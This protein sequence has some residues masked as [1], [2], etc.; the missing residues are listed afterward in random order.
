M[1]DDLA[2]VIALAIDQGAIN[3]SGASGQPT[4][5]ITTAGIGSV[6]GTSIAYAGIVEFQTDVAASNALTDGCAYLAPP[7]VAGLLMQRQRFSGT[8][9][10]LWSGSVL[11]GLVGGFRASTTTQMPAANLLFGD[12]A[13]VVIGSWGVLEVMANPY[14]GFQAGIIGIR[15]FATVDV[16][17]RQAAAFSL[18]TG[19]T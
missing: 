17:V 11:D 6:T 19:I 5:I 1:Q 15:A 18:A 14:A 10:P 9:T 2:K 16:G 8:D 4:G 3:G 12:F 13:Q 7:A